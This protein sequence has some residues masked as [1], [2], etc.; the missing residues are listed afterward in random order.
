[1]KNKV[2]VIVIVLIVAIFIAINY[3]NKDT[4]IVKIG[5]VIPQTGFGAY[6]G[7][8]VLKGIRLAEKDLNKAFSSRKI[9][10]LVEDSQSSVPTA[11]SAAQKLINVDKVDA[12]YS[13]F[14][15]M[16]SAISP[17]AKS[18]NKILVYSTFNQKIAEDNATSIKT[19]ISF[20]VACE[21]F[22]KNV[23]DKTKK[24]L[25]ISAISDAAP[26]C[27]KTLEKYIPATNIKLVEGFTSTDF[28]TLLLQNKE[29]GPDYIIPIMYENG[30]YALIK[31]NHELGL[32][33]KFFCY[34]Q[35]CVTEKLL[36]ELPID[37][38]EG[39]VYFEVA[40][41]D[42]FIQ[43]IKAEYSDMSKDDIQA[44]ANSY[45]SIIAVGEG[46]MECQARGAQCVTDKLANK[47]EFLNVGYKNA[48]F[49]DR[50]LTSDLILSVV[51]N[52]KGEL[53]K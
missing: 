44:A 16:S 17:I 36:K 27:L 21:N 20:E 14:S 13:E 26:Y 46:L 3:R 31:Q 2:L 50:V 6:W 45:Q 30:S 49:V 25:I 40:I 32:K 7:D 24:I 35:D 48:E 38:T 28:K 41:D 9:E 33:S 5:A 19:F 39:I 15:G 42:N 43:K 37:S 29:F 12:I 8:P 47:K 53:I 18:A 51:R 23:L 22:A 52:G 34:K 11:V 4:A 1:M 10:V